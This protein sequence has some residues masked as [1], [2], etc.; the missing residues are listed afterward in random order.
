MAHLIRNPD[1]SNLFYIPQDEFPIYGLDYTGTQQNSYITLNDDGTYS[2]HGYTDTGYT[3]ILVADITEATK[4]VIVHFSDPLY[5][6]M[7]NGVPV[8]LYYNETQY[9]EKYV[10]YGTEDGRIGTGNTGTNYWRL[11]SSRNI[12]RVE[13]YYFTY[14][15]ASP[16]SMSGSFAGLQSGTTA[17]AWE[18]AYMEAPTT[19]GYTVEYYYQNVGGGW[20]APYSFSNRTGEVGST[21]YLTSD[22]KQPMK[23]PTIGRYVYDASRST[24]SGTVIEDPDGMGHALTLRAYFKIQVEPSIALYHQKSDGTWASEPDD[25]LEFGTDLGEE[26]YWGDIGSEVTFSDVYNSI[27]QTPGINRDMSDYVEP[28][29]TPSSGSYAYDE[30]RSV[31]SATLSGT[32]ASDNQFKAYFKLQ[33]TVTFR[34]TAGGNADDTHGELDYGTA[35]PD[36][37]VLSG[38]SP[39]LSPTVTQ[40]VTYTAQWADENTGI[41]VVKVSQLRE[42]VQWL[43][44]RSDLSNIETEGV[45]VMSATGDEAVKIS[46]LKEWGDSVGG[47]L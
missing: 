19:A 34:D 3:Y 17:S 42:Y 43:A 18:S 30:G 21:V 6:H 1:S 33:F 28:S 16:E 15:N 39:S 13:I 29:E 45:M 27:Q 14:T 35:T 8:R 32:D 10:D 25:V 5:A 9:V 37:H 11:S 22:D 12:T 20:G 26:I 38:W 36:G 23:E 31:T 47:G 44:Q 2:F 46:Q 24:E 41:C 4:Q 40:D 7:G